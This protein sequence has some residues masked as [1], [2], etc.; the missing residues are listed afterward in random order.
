MSV[1]GAI[2]KTTCNRD[3][4]DA[5]GLVAT[6]QGERVVELRGDPEH[7]ITRGFLCPRT[8]RFLE[9]QYSPER[10]LS[11]LWRESI[12]A[13]FR[14]ISWDGALDLAAERLVRI[15]AES[16]PAAILHYR[17]GGSLGILLALTDF[18]FERFGPVTT[19]RG[20]ICSGAG[21]AAQ[22]ADFGLR[23]AS[24]LSDLANAR[25]VILW[26]K[27]P[28]TSSP[29]LLPPLKQA[30]A[31]GAGTLLIDPVRHHTATLVDA[32]VQPRPGGDFALAMA[33]ARICFEQGWT[34]PDAVSWCD[35]LDGFRA[36]AFAR[37]VD[38]WCAE[39]DVP[40]AAARDLAQRF[41]V[42]R[43]TTV[44]LGWGLGRKASG[45]ATVRAIDALA[46]V[47]GN[48]G[49]AG[50]GV[51]FYFRR[52]GAFDTS[53][54]T[55]AAPRTLCE[56]LLGRG[57]L[58]AGDPPV[59]AVWVTAGNP[60]VMLPDSRLTAQALRTRDFTV[61]ADSFLT[62]TA[63]CAHLVLP[64]ATLLEADD[65][66]GSYGHP[67][68]AAS[69]PVVQRPEGVRSDV[70][71]MQGLA[72]RTGLGDALAGTAADWKRRILAPRLGPH[73]ITLETLEA[74]AVR[75]PLAPTVV[76]E[77]RQFPTPT[78]RVQ[79]ISEP[80]A[81]APAP[82]PA[83]PLVLMAVSTA[84][85]QCSQWSEAPGLP[86]EAVVH[87]DVAAGVADGG[88]ACLRSRHGAMSIRVR[89]DATQR[90]D[91]VRLAKGGSLHLGLCANAI[92]EARTTD[93]GEG[94]A[95]YDETVKIVAGEFGEP[96][97]D[98]PSGAGGSTPEGLQPP[99][100]SAGRSPVPGPRTSDLGPQTV[101]DLIATCP[102]ELEEVVA[103]EVAEI[104]GTA[105]HRGY[106][107]IHFRATPE[108]FYAAHLKLRSASRVL[109]VV[110]ECAAA[111]PQMLFDQ[112][113]RVDWSSLFDADKTFVIEAIPA[114]GREAQMG[115]EEIVRR[116][117]EGILASFQRRGA[118][119][120]V[121]FE[122]PRVTVVAF[123]GN[124]R[125]NLSL[126]T[127]GKTLDKRGYREDG[128]PAPLKETLAAA[129][130]RIAGYDG[131]RPLLDPMC[132]S[133]TLAIEA[134]MIAVHK[135]PLMH[136][137][138]GEFGFEWL[139]DFDRDLWRHVQERARSERLTTPPNP[140][141]ASDIEPKFVEMARRNALR[142]RVERDIRFGTADFLTMEAPGPAGLLVANL[143][144]GERLGGGDALK[145]FYS[146]V[147]DALK[148]RF[149]GWD[150]ALLVADDSPWK[151]IGL[152]PNR[153][154]ALLNGPI[155]AKL[156]MY[157]IRPW[158][159]RERLTSDV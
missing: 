88:L 104:G 29:H 133:G 24:D 12:E 159:P 126:D 22:E 121:D 57:I 27:N 151:F 140:I 30:R 78:G 119:P 85:S 46:A 41:G 44:L 47:T 134:A 54:V 99:A 141:I 10:L 18:F 123:V 114:A 144:Y 5:C 56:P 139:K 20:D 13:D 66:V 33:A 60:V 107:A 138:K 35:G 58:D 127:A 34:A 110:R 23:D 26:G 152:R 25:T 4:P 19:K 147:G 31:R 82:D 90:R 106:K 74:G 154:V 62:D 40:A 69:R 129:I 158:K 52:R 38:A 113:R 103:A 105:V 21:E 55:G 79:L 143:P 51:S 11:P 132:G 14:P 32:Y 148:R 145:Q 135:P 95:L 128:H 17:S 155:P 100:A 59:R 81:A 80:P 125:A 86:A 8:S 122:D 124:G 43:P 115:R 7:P 63:Q 36:M 117:R 102:A 65:L 68:L 118:V 76:F 53:F 42:D 108:V 73:G 131:S 149:Q 83:W 9:R 94:G 142:A 16:G 101:L 120:R 2:R 6:V 72:A 87:P 91:M 146:D 157:E 64:T 96:T 45:G 98:A 3:C 89:H 28:H 71:I 49:V 153:K 92:I 93:L 1:P 84:A 136:R 156:L 111:T 137:S 150:A 130:L 15:R 77:G 109:R 37:P 75:N 97:A 70:E 116:V 67:F 50:A 48:V 112:V 61:V 39:A